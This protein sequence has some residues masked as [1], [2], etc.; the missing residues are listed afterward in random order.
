[1]LVGLALFLTMFVMA[2]VFD[3]INSC[4]PAA[5]PERADSRPGSPAKGRG[6]AEGVHAGADSHLRPGAVRAPVQAHTDIGVPEAT[7]LTI[8]VPAFVTS[9]LKTAFQIGFRRSS[10]RS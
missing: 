5:L 9:E 8:L 6:T 7:P 10:S 4:G 2:P 1:M 3:K